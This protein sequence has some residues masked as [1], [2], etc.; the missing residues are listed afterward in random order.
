MVATACAEAG[1]KTIYKWILTAYFPGAQQQDWVGSKKRHTLRDAYSSRD[2]YYNKEFI[3]ADVLGGTW[4]R[5]LRPCLSVFMRR[6]NVDKAVNDKPWING[7]DSMLHSW[8]Q[9]SRWTPV[10]GIAFP[11][12][13]SAAASMNSWLISESLNI[14]NVLPE[15]ISTI[16]PYSCESKRSCDLNSSK[17]AFLNSARG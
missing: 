5:E 3:L 6:S 7:S 14:R 12:W 10:V 16:A 9:A 17:T 15:L 4:A 2:W 8:Q 1:Q 11:T 13:K